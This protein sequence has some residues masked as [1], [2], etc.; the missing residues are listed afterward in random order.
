MRLNNALIRCAHRY[1]YG[2]DWYASFINVCKSAPFL[3]RNK[4]LLQVSFSWNDYPGWPYVQ[5]KSGSG[6][7]FSILI[8]AYKFGLDVD[9]CASTWRM[10][11][12][13]STFSVYKKVDE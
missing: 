10:D 7:L 3:L 9:I 8:W 5:I 4:S 6:S 12:Y 13:L 11:D 2:H 1:D